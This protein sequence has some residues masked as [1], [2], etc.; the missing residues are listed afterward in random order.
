M[1]ERRRFGQVGL[2]LRALKI[3]MILTALLILTSFGALVWLIIVTPRTVA[4]KASLVLIQLCFTS[5]VVTLL[6]A[7]SYLVRHAINPMARVE[8]ILDK[9]IAGDCTQRI[10][11]RNKDLMIPFMEK[12]NAVIALLEKN[13]KS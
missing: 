6:M 3:T 9:V 1:K 4:W 11:L 12:V 8:S 2:A 10:S 13:R 5:A 7:I